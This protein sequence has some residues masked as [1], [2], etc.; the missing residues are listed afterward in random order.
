MHCVAH[1]KLIIYDVS[2]STYARLRT[3]TTTT[4]TETLD[5]ADNTLESIEELNENE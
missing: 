1:S 2:A 3:T 5:E 4:A